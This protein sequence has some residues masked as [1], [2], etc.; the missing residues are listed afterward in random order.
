ML[1]CHVIGL[2]SLCNSAGFNPKEELSRRAQGSLSRVLDNSYSQR[3][4][5]LGNFISK[6]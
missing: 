3:Q 2:L 1:S 5:M 6:H 4:G